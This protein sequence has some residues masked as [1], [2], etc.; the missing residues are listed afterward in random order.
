MPSAKDNSHETFQLLYVAQLDLSH[1]AFFADQLRVKG[2]HFEPW[3]VHWK[4]YLHQAA[5]VTS[6][7]VSY[8]RPFTESRSWAKFPKRILRGLNQQQKELHGRLLT[9]RNEVYAHTDVQA[10]KIR[11]ITI[12]GKPSAI[13]VLPSMRFSDTELQ[14]IRELI[15][16]ISFGVNERLEELSKNVAEQHY[17]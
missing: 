2:W 7:V 12:E 15:H 16:V 11:P 10:R 8:G 1:A 6:L 4:K 5:Y 14:E 9:L 17:G 3:E 13:E